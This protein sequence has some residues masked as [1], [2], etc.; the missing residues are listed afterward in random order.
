M[1]VTPG[2]VPDGQGDDKVMDDGNEVSTASFCRNACQMPNETV[3]Y[4]DALD[5]G[6]VIRR[7]TQNILCFL[8]TSRS[9]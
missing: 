9:N 7:S 8:C 2:P 3:E 5:V 1:Q 4:Q 6:Y